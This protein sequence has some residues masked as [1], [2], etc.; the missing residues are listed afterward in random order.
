MMYAEKEAVKLIGQLLVSA[1]TYTYEICTGNEKILVQVINA[2]NNNILEL[3]A[4][5]KI[6]KK[7]PRKSRSK[8]PEV[9]K[10]Q[11]K[12]REIA[13]RK[14][15]KLK[16]DLYSAKERCN[17]FKTQ[18]SSA[19]A[20]SNQKMVSP[21]LD[22]Y[23]TDP[24]CM[25]LS[26]YRCMTSGKY[27]A[28]S[29]ESKW[30]ITPLIVADDLMRAI[31]YQP[32]GDSEYIKCWRDAVNNFK[33]KMAPLGDL[34]PLVEL[35]IAYLS[36]D[37]RV[38]QFP[39]NLSIDQ[40]F[41]GFPA[42]AEKAKSS[43]KERM[44]LRAS[45]ARSY[46]QLSA[47]YEPI[48]HVD[49]VL[50]SAKSS[51]QHSQGSNLFLS[52]PMGGVFNAEVNGTIYNSGSK[53]DGVLLPAVLAALEAGLYVTIVLHRVTLTHDMYNRTKQ[54]LDPINQKFA[55]SVWH[56][57]ERTFIGLAR[58]LVVCVNSLNRPEVR[59]FLTKSGV[60]IFDE[61]TQVIDNLSMLDN[62][63]KGNTAEVRE[64]QK[65]ALTIF[66]LICLPF[67]HP[68]TTTIV[69]D[70]DLD[71]KTVQIIT[72]CTGAPNKAQIFNITHPERQLPSAQRSKQAIFH[73]DIKA[74]GQM[75]Q[76][77][78]G[79][80]EK[81]KSAKESGVDKARFFIAT[82]NK[83][84]TVSISDFLVSMELT[85]CLINADTIKAE[86][87]PLGGYKL[88][89]G[90]ISAAQFDVV[91]YSPTITSGCSWT[92]STYQQ[93]VLIACDTIK[94]GDM[95]QMGFRF[96]HTKQI[97]VF[98]APYLLSDS[99]GSDLATSIP[100][101]LVTEAQYGDGY[102]TMKRHRNELGTYTTKNQR[103]CLYHQFDAEGWGCSTI[104]HSVLPESDN[105]H[106][107]PQLDV[108]ARINAIA[109]SLILT[110]EAV[111]GLID[112]RHQIT[113]SEAYMITRH[114][115][116]VNI[117][118]SYSREV[119]AACLS[120]KTERMISAL[121]HQMLSPIPTEIRQLADFVMTSLHNENW[122][123]ELSQ[124]NGI[125]IDTGQIFQLLLEMFDNPAALNGLYALG[126]F[127][128][129][130]WLQTKGTFYI[131]DVAKVKY[132]D[133]LLNN[134]TT[135]LEA[136]HRAYSLC[137][138]SVFVV[139][140]KPERISV[141]IIR[142]ILT[143][144]GISTEVSR[145]ELSI[146]G[147]ISCLIAIAKRQK[148]MTLIDAATSD[149]LVIGITLKCWPRPDH[150]FD[151]LMGSNSE[152]TIT[153][154][155][156][157]LKPLVT[158]EA[159]TK[160]VGLVATLD[161]KLGHQNTIQHVYMLNSDPLPQTDT[162]E[163]EKT[164]IEH[165]FINKSRDKNTVTPMHFLAVL[166]LLMPLLLSSPRIVDSMLEHL[167]LDVKTFSINL[168]NLQHRLG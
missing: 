40:V 82:D 167:E 130:S 80:V 132:K 140:T 113:L 63:E 20:L 125:T 143:Q 33:A 3:N 35:A 32:L 64:G 46:T 111:Q 126:F 4:Q 110:G 53:T 5:I 50:E 62:S 144:C 17:T 10:E 77:I 7:L 42:S 23:P 90:E 55:K 21:F 158:G 15:S 31:D 119:I 45:K 122:F 99:I 16:Q 22:V 44:Q 54:Y 58:V 107:I 85:V 102:A 151:L 36:A 70:A 9:F 66:D 83:N 149:G 69:I 128:S 74:K 89:S 76:H 94:S 112:K 152:I 13:E 88:V 2:T 47:G 104:D 72:G 29:D 129:Y 124:G 1:N 12:A 92:D 154:T 11:N 101:D 52:A 148:V 147:C 98:A 30:L 121:R 116:A 142:K 39:H 86:N 135:R 156:E 150:G 41:D 73:R 115:T 109:D 79:L 34:R 97:D 60:V 27:F 48:S 51:I 162:E 159:L 57:K 123:A 71:D 165:G 146:D 87:E 160:S 139:N 131:V 127:E 28:D 14:L 65:Q 81:R 91:V 138:G 49:T 59:E 120:V 157:V 61:F 38:R 161:E 114:H 19:Q 75:L 56:Y 8:N 108:S 133:N 155:S 43:I 164:D 25:L 84:L 117:A 78:A 103:S 93:G 67:S 163:T 105:E 95:K 100:T 145:D 137:D 96:R 118:V 37:S 26:N 153:G 166:R 141:Q 24:V 18:L 134:V 68:T 168:Q 136:T 106:S 6:A